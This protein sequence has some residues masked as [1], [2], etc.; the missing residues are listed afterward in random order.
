MLNRCCP[1]FFF[2]L[3]TIGAISFN[4]IQI[5]LDIGIGHLQRLGSWQGRRRNL[6]WN[7]PR[8]ICSSL[9]SQKVSFKIIAIIHRLLPLYA[10]C[11]CCDLFIDKRLKKRLVS[12]WLDSIR[13][14]STCTRNSLPIAAI[15]HSTYSKYVSAGFSTVSRLKNTQDPPFDNLNF[16]RWQNGHWFFDDRLRH[17]GRHCQ[18]HDSTE[19]PFH[20]FKQYPDVRNVTNLCHFRI[21][22]AN[23]VLLIRPSRFR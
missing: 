4:V 10:D 16:C 6:G 18:R 23:Y 19:S 11:V 22:S 5:D 14:V 8:P 12:R 9:D 7:L 3:E 2:L 17:S 1:F 20:R 15:S 21:I 13:G